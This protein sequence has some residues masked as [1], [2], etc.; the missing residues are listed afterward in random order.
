MLV[1]TACVR[2]PARPSLC[3]VASST[4]ELP[5]EVGTPPSLQGLSDTYAVIDI[6]G[7]QHIV[8]EGRWYTCNRLEVGPG[9]L[10]PI[11]T[12]QIAVA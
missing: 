1:G 9:P 7:V 12:M 10:S 6:G 5:P 8:E 4:A 3:A 11:H 2:H